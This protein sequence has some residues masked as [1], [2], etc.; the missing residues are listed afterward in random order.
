MANTITGSRILFGILMLCFPVFSVPFYAFYLAA[1]L[2]DMIDGP[3]ARH[4]HEETA[5]GAKFD[6][7]A[8]LLFVLCCMIKILPALPLRPWMI[9]GIVI[10]AVIRIGTMVYG[11]WKSK[12]LIAEHTILNKITGACLF[13]FPFTIGIVPMQISILTLLV[14]SFLAAVEEPFS[15]QKNN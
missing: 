10:V 14:I 5:F 9:V 13:L 2:S 7:I 3:I 15:R 1:G 12:K 6:S 11:F 4:R 8:D